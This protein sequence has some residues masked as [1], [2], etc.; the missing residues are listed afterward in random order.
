MLQ[1]AYFLVKIGT[2]TAENE[3]NFAENL[4]KFWQIAGG[5]RLG[6]L[7]ESQHV[8]RPA[9]A[10]RGCT[11]RGHIWGLGLGGSGKQN[12]KNL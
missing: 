5:A 4:P 3:R 7:R 11:A 9:L 10:T 1:N 12:W 2:D 6:G 8:R